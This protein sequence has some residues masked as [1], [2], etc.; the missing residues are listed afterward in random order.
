[1]CLLLQSKRNSHSK[2]RE[3][4][5]VLDQLNASRNRTEKEVTKVSGDYASF[6]D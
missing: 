4:E 2:C 1:M 6:H 5:Q 3:L